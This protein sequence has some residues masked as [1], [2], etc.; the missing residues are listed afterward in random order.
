MFLAV[1]SIICQV[2]SFVTT[3]ALPRPLEDDCLLNI[4]CCHGEAMDIR[5]QA[6]HCARE[7]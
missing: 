6:G 5:Q 4:H 2:Q 7:P 3:F 1:A